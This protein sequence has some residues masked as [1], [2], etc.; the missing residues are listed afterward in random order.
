MRVAIVTGASSGIGRAT[1]LRLAADGMAILAVGRNAGALKELCDQVA[2][3]GVEA[4]PLI[5]DVTAADSPRL[6]VDNAIF[7]WGGIDAL[8]NGAGI[9]A[10]GSVTDTTDEAFDTM[11]D[12]N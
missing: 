9:I 7:K 11:M 12:I 4:E 6:I 8:V 2:A 1:C 10:S 5:A 3:N